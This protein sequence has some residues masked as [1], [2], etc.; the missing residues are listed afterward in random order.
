[1]CHLT[2]VYQLFQDAIHCK[3]HPDF[4]DVK[5]VKLMGWKGRLGPEYESI[6]KLIIDQGITS[7]NKIN[8]GSSWGKKKKNPEVLNFA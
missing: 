8:C 6:N 5:S 3:K 7:D 4:R 1:M 2:G